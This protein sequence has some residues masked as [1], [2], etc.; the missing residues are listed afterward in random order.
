MSD[1]DADFANWLEGE[2]EKLDKDARGKTFDA[3]WARY[4]AFPA[5]PQDQDDL[6]EAAEAA[7]RK[8]AEKHLKAAK[9]FADAGMY[10][11]SADAYAAAAADFL[12]AG[13]INDINDEHDEALP[14]L[15]KAI[16]AFNDAALQAGSV[17]GNGNQERAFSKKA[18]DI[19]N[20]FY[21]KYSTLHNP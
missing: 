8:A 1:P 5:D 19:Y 15:Q 4:G 12:N 17:A 21:P 13:W 11:A 20:R 2:A 7:L 18:R 9:A 16:N 3:L 14:L 6:D 10:L